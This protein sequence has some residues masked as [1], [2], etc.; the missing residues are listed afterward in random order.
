MRGRRKPCAIINLPNFNN[1]EW[2]LVI[3]GLSFGLAQLECYGREPRNA[4]SVM[5]PHSWSVENKPAFIYCTHL[6]ASH[7]RE[8]H[9]PGEVSN[10]ILIPQAA[11]VAEESFGQAGC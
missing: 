2:R 10:T 9:D 7:P 1:S 5:S 4:S 6:P 11:A 8:R 3:G